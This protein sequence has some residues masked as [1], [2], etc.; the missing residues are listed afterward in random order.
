MREQ[1]F[2]L[3]WI[4][5]LKTIFIQTSQ[6][7]RMTTFSRVVLKT[8]G[9]GKRFWAVRIS[10]VL[11][12]HFLDV[13]ERQSFVIFHL[14]QPEV[15]RV[16]IEHREDENEWRVRAELPAVP[17]VR[18]GQAREQDGLIFAFNYSDNFLVERLQMFVQLLLER[19]QSS[20]DEDVHNF[21]SHIKLRSDTCQMFIA[22]HTC[23]LM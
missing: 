21:F 19:S 16:E 9:S 4:T 5:N 10:T 22:Y 11:H 3:R 23:R 8:K 13:G 2:N 7:R 20:V 17:K 12:G 1:R 14:V 15:F 18:L 6:I